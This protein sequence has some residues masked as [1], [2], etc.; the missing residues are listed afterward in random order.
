MSQGV[1]RLNDALQIGSQAIAEPLIQIME[2]DNHRD[3]DPTTSLSL[4]D[5]VKNGD[6]E[7]WEQFVRI[8]SPV[9]YSR[10]RN[11]DL[12]PDESADAM[13][14]VFLKV[15]QGLSQFEPRKD[16]A[17][18]R[19]WLRT[20]ATHTVSDHFRVVAQHFQALDA[21]TL[22]LKLKRIEDSFSEFP[23]DDSHARKQQSGRQLL[24]YSAMQ[25]IRGEFEERTW[26]AF[27]RTTID[28]QKAVDVAS[29]LNMSPGAVRTA[30]YTVRK[31]LREELQ[32]FL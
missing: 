22:T 32:E 28:G 19:S 6:Q 25:Q 21:A 16:R 2:Q 12:S 9:I 7:A 5:R 17:S 8:Y 23:A 4:I 31:R 29:E 14:T 26:T 27:W 18:F 10:C 3:I 11:G 15:Y 30:S 13:Q 20:V 24:A 1:C